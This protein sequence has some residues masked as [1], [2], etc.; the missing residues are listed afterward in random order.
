MTNGL[1]GDFIALTYVRLR[2]STDVRAEE[3]DQIVKIESFEFEYR[4]FAMKTAGIFFM[5]RLLWFFEKRGG[6]DEL[7]QLL[8]RIFI[9]GVVCCIRYPE[10]LL[11]K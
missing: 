10:T 8:M 7:P 1:H 9:A 2:S 3:S 5:F 6:N 4:T 11:G